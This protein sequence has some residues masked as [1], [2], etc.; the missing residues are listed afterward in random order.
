MGDVVF[1]RRDGSRL[2]INEE[3]NIPLQTQLDAVLYFL[4]RLDSNM[5]ELILKEQK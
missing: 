4:E 3:G 5:L 2:I 1:I